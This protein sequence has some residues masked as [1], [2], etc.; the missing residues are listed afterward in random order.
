MNVDLLIRLTARFEVL[1]LTAET[2]SITFGTGAMFTWSDP[3]A[4]AAV[5]GSLCAFLPFC[6]LDSW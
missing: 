2:L 5:G 3:R 4:L 1:Y 6:L